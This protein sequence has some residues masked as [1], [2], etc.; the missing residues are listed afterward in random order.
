MNLLLNP[1]D[2]S[3]AEWDAYQRL[4]VA[5]ERG[6]SAFEEAHL[7]AVCGTPERTV[8]V[9]TTIGRLRRSSETLPSVLDA[10][11][12]VDFLGR[13]VP[14]SCGPGRAGRP[15]RAGGARQT[16]PRPDWQIGLLVA[17]TWA[18]TLFLAVQTVRGLW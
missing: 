9:L 8:Q 2:I 1:A 17:A 18:V 3:T 12:H 14:G 15:G 13:P 7:L 4:A 6:H 5:R 10:V 11:G 16:Q